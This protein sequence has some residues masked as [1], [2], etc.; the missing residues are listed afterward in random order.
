MADITVSNNVQILPPL[1]DNTVPGRKGPPRVVPD[2]S[3]QVK[4]SQSQIG[5]LNT[6]VN[7]ANSA[8]LSL[9]GTVSTAM[10]GQTAQAKDN[11]QSVAL[12]SHVDIKV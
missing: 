5:A 6:G 1:R 8:G 11:Q 10:S 9:Y 7:I 3:E 4:T 12:G 2:A